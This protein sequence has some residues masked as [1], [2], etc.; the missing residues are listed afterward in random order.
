MLVLVVV[1]AVIV[2]VKA[3]CRKVDYEE[4]FR[5]W[6]LLKQFLLLHHFAYLAFHFISDKLYS[7]G[8][9]PPPAPEVLISFLNIFLFS[10]GFA[11]LLLEA[12]RVIQR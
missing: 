9:V 2:Y 8:L 4:P 7:L 5:K 12:L 11:E 10:C 6:R 3:C 1:F